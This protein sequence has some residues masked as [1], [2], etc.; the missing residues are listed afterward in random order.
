MRRAK[1]PFDP[2]AMKAANAAVQD[3]T[4]P[5]GRPLDPTSPGDAELRAK[6]MDAY[7]EAGGETEVVRGNSQAARTQ[8]KC[9]ADGKNFIELRYLHCDG[10]PVKNAKY[11]IATSIEIKD[12]ELDDD[13]FVRIDGL[14]DIG[15]FSY[16]FYDDPEVYEPEG[17]IESSAEGR[18]EAIDALNRVGE[19]I[20]E[21]AQGDFN[22]KQSVG[23]IAVNTVLGL[24]PIVDQVLDV[25]D[26]IAG[27]KNI[28]VFYMESDDEQAK[29]EESL[30]LSYETWLW[31][32]LFLIA[33]G[34]IPTLG[35]AVKGVLKVIIRGM[36]D[37]A[38]SAGGLTVAQWRHIW[39]EAL[40]V[41]NRLG[42]A[43]GNAHRWLDELAGKIPGLM[44]EAA[45]K[46][47]YALDA[48]QKMADA[49]EAA[50]RRFSG[51]L[52]SKLS[53]DQIIERARR[54]KNALAK[55]YNRL[56]ETKRR[57]NDWICEQVRKVVGA[58]TPEVKPGSLNAPASN[59]TLK[60][61]DAAPPEVQTP[62]ATLVPPRLAKGDVYLV[63]K[64]TGH[65]LCQFDA[66]ETAADG[67]VTLIEYKDGTG[68]GKIN[69]KTGQPYVDPTTQLERFG[70]TQ[71]YEAGSKK[72]AGLQQA[73]ANPSGVETRGAPATVDEIRSADTIRFDVKGD[74][75][76]IRAET[77]ARLADLRRAY[78]DIVF[79]AR[80]GV[81]P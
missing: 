26:L 4:D 79:E 2:G 1:R 36:Q 10:T 56:E 49:A 81:T 66:I 7:A 20:W 63:D 31:L 76:A 32:G 62:P 53:A 47:R 40:K 19:W 5:P 27:L 6:W 30:G 39:E 44:D 34:C 25:R 35:S 18:Q 70:Q 28:I 46:I 69:P 21:T 64:T 75:P 72:A 71:I 80:Y 50:A 38:K 12:G 33:I 78:P 22:D 8:E 54:Y 14:P 43:Q 67:K 37:A 42:V 74:T 57:I 3:L 65:D 9:A 29:H 58:K 13:G 77:E 23:Q 68:I 48:I 52:I 16:Y 73:K 17:P 15:G 59:N 61:G 41:L 60:Q 24:I 11:H 51:T 45:Q 55:A